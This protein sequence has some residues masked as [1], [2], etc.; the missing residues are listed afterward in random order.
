MHMTGNSAL[1]GRPA[2]S[3]GQQNKWAFLPFYYALIIIPAFVVLTATTAVAQDV[4]ITN[5]AELVDV[6]LSGNY[7]LYL[8]W[9]PWQIEACPTDNGEPWWMDCSQMD[10]ADLLSTSTNS[11]ATLQIHGVT[12]TFVTLTKNILTGE[13]L[14]SSGCSTDVIT[15]IAAPSGYDPGTLLGENAWVWRQWQQV[16]NCLDCWGLVAG[17]IPPPIVT[18]KTRL[19][20]ASTYPVYQSNV[21]ADAEAAAAAWAAATTASGDADAT[22]AGRFMAMD[23]DDISCTIT[24]ET[25]PFSVTQIDQD[26]SGNTYLTW[27]SCSD[28]I[29]G[30]FSSADMSN[31]VG[32]AAMWGDDLSTTWEDTNTAGG[33]ATQFYKVVRVPPDEGFNGDAIPSGWAVDN[34]LNP[35]DPNL[36]VEDPDNDFWNNLAEYQNGTD[37]NNPSSLAP[38]SFTI[39]GGADETTN[40]QVQ[41]G[42]PGLVADYVIISESITMTN[43][44]TNSFVSPLTYALL[45][46]N[47]GLHTIYMQLLKASGPLSPVFGRTVELDTHPPTISITTPTNGITV[48]QRLINIEGFA[49]DA[50]T[51]NATVSDASRPLLVTVNGDFVN[52]RDTN[53]L[54]WSAQDLTPGTNTFTAIATDR[55]GWAVTNLVWLIYDPTLATNVPLLTVDV[56]NTIT[57][58]SNATTIA[59]SGTIDDGNATIQID[60]LDAI[61]NTIT[62]ATVGTAMIGTNWWAEVPVVAG[63]NLVV[64]SAANANSPAATNSFLITQNTNVFLEIDSPAADTDVNAT[65]VLVVG[66]ASTN[67]NASITINGVPANT[68]LD[69]NGITFSNSVSINSVDG[70][71]IQVQA[72]GT[73]GS[74]ATASENVYGYEV[75]AFNEQETDNW[76][77]VPL[78]GQ[79]WFANRNPDTI[80]YTD[81]EMD[82]D[83]WASPN[84]LIVSTYDDQQRSLSGNIL[85]SDDDP[86]TSSWDPSVVPDLDSGETHW[87]TAIHWNHV[88]ANLPIQ[89]CQWDQDCQCLDT[90]PYCIGQDTGTCCINTVSELG[91]TLKCHHEVTFV[92]HW[93]TTEE[94]TVILH[95]DDFYYWLNGGGGGLGSNYGSD[96][97]GVAFWGKPGFVY[98]ITTNYDLG[99]GFP[100]TNV[101]FVVTIKT[102]TRYT[103]R[104]TD[105]TVPRFDEDVT[106]GVVNSQSSTHE[107]DTRPDAHLLQLRE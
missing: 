16:T 20:D 87:D 8:P 46:T 60:V 54:W 65:N 14:L 3:P 97:S 43:G 95:F 86:S 47:D 50:S 13:T 55:A 24:D 88:N 74:S 68:S 83:T 6:A 27:T 41:L 49:A 35:L 58:A 84:A 66:H 53:G 52:D 89:D 78:Y 18:L 12:V 51:T 106:Y 1:N 75:L 63:S 107:H 100:M 80:A 31:W 85:S 2:C 76:G 45:N 105:F 96:P 103:F 39:N 90:P 91:E 7:S 28:H 70:N 21:V 38:Y 5:L 10:C 94:Q 37:P 22:G 77:H 29:Y 69:S 81:N 93:P 40:A 104:D 9:T 92:K 17:E 71:T 67:F 19:A 72:S 33:V 32:I 4:T 34:G 57:V 99:P 82:S 26:R 79:D 44:V 23:D 36:D 30:V 61:D 56:T 48:S 15:T 42:F 98:S 102:N 73:D 25:L 59:I 62:N 11:C 64:V 101:G